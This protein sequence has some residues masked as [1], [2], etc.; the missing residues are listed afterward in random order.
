MPPGTR[1]ASG[2]RAGNLPAQT[3]RHNDFVL[4]SA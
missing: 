3:S 4:K 2:F 1:P